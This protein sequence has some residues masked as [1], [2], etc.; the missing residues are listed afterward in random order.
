MGR[1]KKKNR[2]YFTEEE[3]LSFEKAGYDS[4][5][6]PKLSYKT[7]AQKIA[8]EQIVKNTITFLGGPAGT[9]KSFLPCFEAVQALN[10]GYVDRIV[11]TRPMVEATNSMGHLPGS[12]NDKIHPYLLPLLDNLEEILGPEKVKQLLEEEVIKFEPINF[13]RGRT[14]KNAFII[15]DEV[16]NCKQS[17]LKLVLT[18]IGEDSKVVVTYDEDQVDIKRDKSCIHHIPYF[19]GKPNIGYFSFQPSDV[20]RSEIAKIV[21]E[22][23]EEI[24]N[25]Q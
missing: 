2:S 1:N 14:L 8:H 12:A 21:V 24:E 7:E 13:L 4:L 20:I 19:F 25:C 23:Y 16:Q 10:K 22:T 18:R 6:L 9:G 3:F 5:K 11:L 15:L 17:E